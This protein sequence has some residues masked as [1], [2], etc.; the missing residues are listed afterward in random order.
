MK[1][2]VGIYIPPLSSGLNY[3]NFVT[4]YLWNLLQSY[5][6]EDQSRNLTTTLQSFKVFYGYRLKV[7]VINHTRSSGVPLLRYVLLLGTFTMP[8]NF[9]V[10]EKLWMH[11]SQ[12][13]TYVCVYIYIYIYIYTRVYKISNLFVLAHILYLYFFIL[14]MWH[15]FSSKIPQEMHHKLGITIRS[16]D[17]Y[18]S[19]VSREIGLWWSPR[20]KN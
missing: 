14:S 18:C 7:S 5:S 6:P 20:Q 17:G 16:V 4:V 8:R 13:S 10:L 15:A 2:F 11:E 19:K 1:C 9:P 3:G 12:A